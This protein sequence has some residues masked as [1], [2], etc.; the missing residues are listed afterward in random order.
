VS[1]FGLFESRASVESPAVPLTSTQLLEWLD[2]GTANDSGVP[3]SQTT[4]MNLSAVYRAV[5]LVSSVA[6][7]LPLIAYRAGTKQPAEVP[8]LADPHPEM[9]PY[10]FWKLSYVHRLLW[11]NAYARRVT[12]RAG[13]VLSLRPLHPSRVRPAEV[14]AT[15]RNPA[16]K[17]FYVDGDTARPLLPHEMFH[18]PGLSFDGISGVSVIRHA[19]Q[20]LGLGLAAEKYGAKFFGKGSLLSGIL[21]TEQRLERP[22]ADALKD[23]WRKKMTGI[24]HAHDVAVLDSGA[25]FQPLTMPHDDAQF[26]E[27]RQFQVEE[28]ARWFGVPPFLLMLTEKSTSWG[29]GLEQQTLAWL[30]YSLNPTWLAP[31]EQRVTRL[32]GRGVE[33]RYKVRELLRGDSEARSNFYR[34]MRELGV[35][36]SDDIRAEEDLPPLPDEAGQEYWQPV[37]M[38]PLGTTP[39]ADASTGEGDGAD[40]PAE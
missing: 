37:N 16:G 23:Q 14:E 26:L 40:E 19:A 9:T 28:I 11:G 8:L 13:R 12:D 36:N 27:S 24:E 1:L 2:G 7:A 30:N 10:E 35:F 6:A 18:I 15:A 22:Q 33:V 29:T 38:A 31:T 5:D 3:V 20:S 32:T 25:K 39:G 21:Q 4:A 17:V 34:T